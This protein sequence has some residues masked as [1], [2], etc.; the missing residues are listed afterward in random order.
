[1]L[2]EGLAPSHFTVS[3]NG[4][5]GTITSVV[6][7]SST[8]EAAFRVVLVIDNSASMLP[9]LDRVLADMDVLMDQL[10]NDI[11][12]SVVSFSED[13]IN[14]KG[15]SLYVNASPF[16]YDLKQVKSIYTNSMR[17][18]YTTRTFLYDAV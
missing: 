16:L 7:L 4:R 18:Q 1:K 12:I 13:P 14:L 8:R 2:V 11:G 6:P 9:R 5:P 10:S 17:K 15:Q 3:K